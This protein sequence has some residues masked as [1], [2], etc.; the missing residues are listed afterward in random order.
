MAPAIWRM[1]SFPAEE[2]RTDLIKKKATDKP[3]ND[4]IMAN[5]TLASASETAI[6]EE[7]MNNN[8]EVGE[9]G[10]EQSMQTAISGNGKDH[11]THAD[12]QV[13]AEQT[14]IGRPIPIIP[15]FRPQHSGTSTRPAQIPARPFANGRVPLIGAAQTQ[16][17]HLPQ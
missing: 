10:N 8:D 3:T 1:R 6:M 4:E 9:Q 11:E 5:Q 17:I 16:R 12:P 15:R 7:N 13:P 2:F 14:P